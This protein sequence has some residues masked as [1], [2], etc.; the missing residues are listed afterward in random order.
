MRDVW[1]VV[2]INSVL[3]IMCWLWQEIEGV[4]RGACN[5]GEVEV[6]PRANDYNLYICN[7]QLTSVSEGVFTLN[8][9]HN[10]TKCYHVDRLASGIV[11][12]SKRNLGL[13]MLKIMLSFLPCSTVGSCQT[14]GINGG[15]SYFSREYCLLVQY[16][17]NLMKDHVSCNNLNYVFART[18]L[19][20]WTT[21]CVTGEEEGVL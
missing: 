8:S 14:T 19:L 12:L 6:Y 5:V 18:I 13:K 3:A 10:F 21:A 15:S 16:K 9:L 7:A 17:K 1:N 11:M 20:P 2:E 4:E